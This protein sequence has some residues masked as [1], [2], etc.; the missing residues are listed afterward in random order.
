ML[1]LDYLLPL[2]ILA[3]LALALCS[4]A[5]TPDGVTPADE[6]VC[7]GLPRGLWGSCVSYC[8][9]RDCHLEYPHASQQA[10]Q[11]GAETYA[12][13]ARKLGL[14]PLPPCVDGDEDGVDNLV[15]NCREVY[16]PEQADADGNGIGDACEAME[17][18]PGEE[19]P[20]EEGP[21]DN[22]PSYEPPAA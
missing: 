1:R 4:A 21:E 13:K 3:L 14:S 11:Q 5:K 15:D 8:E 6:T 10:C 22:P 2:S 19:E 12:K 18:P 16:N 9:A 17:A 20:S 7:D